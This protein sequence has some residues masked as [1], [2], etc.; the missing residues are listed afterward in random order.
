MRMIM[1]YHNNKP[2][3]NPRHREEKLQDIY[4][5]KTSKRHIKQSNQLYLPRKDDFKT[6]KDIKKCIPNQKQGQS[7][8]NQWV[9]HSTIFS[10]QKQAFNESLEFCNRS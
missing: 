4:S 1:K 5:N 10:F 7:P 6:R 2:Q 3:T 8:H 9:V